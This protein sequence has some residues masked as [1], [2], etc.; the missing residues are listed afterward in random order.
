MSSTGRREK[1][2]R[3]A[4]LVAI[5]LLLAVM[6]AALLEGAASFYLLIDEMRTTR[7]ITERSHTEYDPD[8]GWV[9]LPGVDIPDLYGPGRA[10]RTNSQRLRADVD[11]S[12]DVPTD[13]TRVICSGD[14]FT[15]GHGVGNEHTWCHELTALD[16][17]LETLN[18]GQGG[19][20]AGQAYLWYKRDGVGFDHD[21]HLFTF[22][23]TDFAR[24][25]T[26][27]SFRGYGK[28]MLRLVDGNLEVTNTPVPRPAYMAP[29]LF[30]N[31]HAVERLALTQLLRKT[32][33][34]PEEE[35]EE[36]QASRLVTIAGCEMDDAETM[37]I[38]AA[39][40]EDLARINREKGSDL[41]LV[42][43][44]RRVDYR[45][46]NSDRWR[47]VLRRQAAQLGIPY[48]DLIEDL[49]ALGEAEVGSF[50]LPDGHLTV[51]GNRWVAERILERLARRPSGETSESEASGHALQ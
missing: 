22:I 9:N 49:N 40:F 41:V 29:R 16:P 46:R 12:I 8:L 15:L 44:P 24:R 45:T 30:Q 25:L 1:I 21:I 36:T 20:G 35:V 37:G 33:G 19:Y 32:R 42:H 7:L 23:T 18:M 39:M 17:R 47:K 28:P 31:L 34:E 51:A 3:A 4:R 43:L 13:R 2:L 48:L 38:T 26:C 5:N 11:Y 27:D 50:F 6:L 14:S 10:L